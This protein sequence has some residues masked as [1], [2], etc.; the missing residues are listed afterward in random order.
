M[1]ATPTHS[2]SQLPNLLVKLNR[3]Q[4]TGTVTIKDNTRSLR[5]YLNQ[6]H[7][8]GADGLDA[9]RRLIKELTR[10]KDLSSKSIGELQQALEK[11]PGSLG[12]V[13]V[14]RG[15]IKPEVWN[16]FLVFKVKQTLTAALQMNEADLGFSE[17]SVDLAPS[18]TIDYNLFQLIM[19]TVKGIRDDAFFRRHIPG[20]DQVYEASAEDNPLKDRVSL[21][22]SEEGVFGLVDGRRT[23]KEIQAASGMDETGLY[24]VVYLLSCFGLIE[25]G[26]G[27][28]GDDEVDYEE[29]AQVYLDLLNIVE[30]NFRKEVGKQF[31]KVYE[32]SVRELGP[33]SGALFESLIISKDAQAEF[34]RQLAAR[35]R[36]EAQEGDA[37]LFLKT[38]FNK[39]LYLLIMRMKRLLGVGLTE[40]TIREMMNILEYVE[41]YRQ[42]AEMMNYVKGNLQ[43][44]L[45]R[46]KS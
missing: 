6:G 32:E 13:L 30:A 3:D 15:L 44:Y 34:P 45:R 26:A 18:D 11:A 19:E 42:E 14:E 37:V 38:S 46:I 36:E 9:E 40:K 29:T 41:K 21:T 8:V 10:K 2:M 4:M 1:G 43:D 17:T 28:A 7:I 31:E 12:R 39:L 24:K 25:P 23:L 35:C 33:R 5:L 20:L 22:P 16:R 27:S